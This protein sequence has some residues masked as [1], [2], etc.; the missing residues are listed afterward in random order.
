MDIVQA[1]HEDEEE[2]YHDKDEEPI[3]TV[4]ETYLGEKQTRFVFLLLQ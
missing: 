4:T 3:P 2:E 1:L